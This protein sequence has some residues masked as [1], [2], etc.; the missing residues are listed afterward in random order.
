MRRLLFPDLAIIEEIYSEFKWNPI[1][2]PLKDWRVNLQ[3]N[4]LIPVVE[5]RIVI[6]MAHRQARNNAGRQLPWLAIPQFGRVPAYER[7]IQRLA[8]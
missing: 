3:W 8:N 5:V 4:S 6:G 1:Q 7:L 2:H